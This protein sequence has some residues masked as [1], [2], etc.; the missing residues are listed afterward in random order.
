MTPP[1]FAIAYASAAVKAQFGASPCRVYPF[2]EA[3]QGVVLPYAVWQQVIGAPENYLGQVPDMDA[4]TTQVDVYAATATAAR[5]AGKALRD[6]FE[7]VAH[8]TRWG[9]EG[10][11]RD[12]GHY[13]ISFDVEWMVQR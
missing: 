11:D 6:A 1:L 8:I 3:P 12:T 10:Q 4:Y 13:R 2:G 5:N 9:G 7:P